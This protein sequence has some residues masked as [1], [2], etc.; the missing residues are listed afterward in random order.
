MPFEQIPVLEVDG[1]QIPQSLAI[2]RYLARK[3]GK[4]T[5]FLKRYERKLKELLLLG[6]AGSTPY[7]EAIVDALAD[8]Y[9]DF[10]VEIK[11]Y[12]Y[13]AMG[14]AEGDVVGLNFWKARHSQRY[15]SNFLGGS[16]EEHSDPCT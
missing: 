10:Y 7:E 9:K 6:Y 8:Q 12:Y 4:I 3:F 16:E 11:D 1:Q 15:S 13:P 5:M 14:L 2:A